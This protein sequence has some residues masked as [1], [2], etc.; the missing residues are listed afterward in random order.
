M[1]SVFAVIVIIFLFSINANAEYKF[2]ENWSRSDTEW[3]AAS[4]ALGVADWL[5]TRYISKHPDE[6]RELNVIL[7]DHPSSRDVNLY[8]G[9]VIV[10]QTILAA[11]LP[12]EAEVFDYKINP[13]RICQGVWISVEG[14]TVIRN[15][16]IGIGFEF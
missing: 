2:A 13:R 3:Q 8:F 5:Q 9:S 10:A 4:I 16:T 14:V 11:A 15:I 6:Y 7:G 1:K 12:P